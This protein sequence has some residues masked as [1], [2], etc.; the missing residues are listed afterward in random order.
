[1]NKLRELFQKYREMILYLIFGGLTTLVNIVCYALLAR[2]AGMDVTL[3]TAIAWAVSVVFAYLTNRKWV[4]QSKA[5][6][7]KAVSYEIATFFGGRV[8]SGLLDIGIM[9]L[10]VEWLGFNDL[11]VKILSNVLVI[12]L[13]YLIS[14]WI[15]FRKKDTE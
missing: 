15:V 6:G 4:F 10:F 14:K 12:I 11:I 9:F 5:I 8:F 3:S 2:G 7:T 1:M 13:N